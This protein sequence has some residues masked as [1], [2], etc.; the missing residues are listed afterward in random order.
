[1][2]FETPGAHFSIMVHPGAHFSLEPHLDPFWT[3]PLWTRC[4]LTFPIE[5]VFC[6]PLIFHHLRFGRF[7]EEDEMSEI[8]FSAL[9]V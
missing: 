9:S 6:F 7:V 2:A 5:R 3:S 1:M 8:C 4:T